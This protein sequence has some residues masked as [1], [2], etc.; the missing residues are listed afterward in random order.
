[1][2]F[3]ENKPI[4]LQIGEQLIGDL[5]SGHYH[6]GERLPSVRECA[7]QLGVNPNTVMRTYSWLQNEGY[8][9]N[10]RGIGYFFVDNAAERYR[11]RKCVDFMEN[12]IPIFAKRMLNLG[13]NPEMVV[14]CARR[15]KV[16]RKFFEDTP[17]VN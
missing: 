1:M 16:D 2:D 4:Y 12:E 17:T 3:N 7:A 6:D 8:I 13:I 5:L 15:M 10:Q 14:D 11:F 9:K